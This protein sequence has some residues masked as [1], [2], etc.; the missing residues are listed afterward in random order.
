MKQRSSLFLKIAFAL[1]IAILA[2]LVSWRLTDHNYRKIADPVDKL[3]HPN[4]PL[5]LVSSLFREV[6]ALDV[7][8]R[9]LANQKGNINLDTFFFQVQTINT[10]LSRLD[11]L[12]SDNPEQ[13]ARIN[14]MKD[15]LQ[16]KVE[17]FQQLA[18][19]NK[20]YKQSDTLKHEVEKLTQYIN[21]ESVAAQPKNAGI[22]KEATQIK[23]TTSVSKD[24]FVEQKRSTWDKIWGKKKEKVKLPPVVKQETKEEKVLVVDTQLLAKDNKNISR[25][26]TTIKTIAT[27]QNTNLN[28]I[29]KKRADLEETNSML[30]AAFISVLTEIE[31]AAKVED[32]S[33]NLAAKSIIESGLD[34][35]R[36]LLIGF[37]VLSAILATLIFYD[38]AKS[39]RYKKALIIAKEQADEAGMAK[40][41]F[42]SNMSHELRTPLQSI[43]GYTELVQRE[44]DSK[45]QQHFLK[46][47]HQSSLH[48]LHIVNEIL[49]FNKINT[50]KF[51]IMSQPFILA[52]VVSQVV[53]IIKIQANRKQLK[54]ETNLHELNTQTTLVGDPFRLKQI[55]LNLLN[56]AIKFTEK[57][58]VSLNIQNVA[59]Q[60]CITCCFEI[61]D[62]GIGIAEEHQQ[63][64]FNEFEQAPTGQLPQGSGLGLSI[65]KALVEL[66]Q[67]SITLDSIVGRGSTFLVCIPYATETNNNSLGIETFKQQENKNPA[68]LVWAIDDDPF[69]LE[70]CAEVFKRNKIPYQCFK[71][72]QEMLATPIPEVLNYILMDIRMPEYSGMEL[73]RLMKNRL[74]ENHNAQFIAL[75]AQVLPEEIGDLFASG[76][77]SL[78]RKPFAI[79]Q[80]LK[81][82][83]INEEVKQADMPSLN[84]LDNINLLFK[85]ETEQDLD[86]IRKNKNA[87]AAE[88]L[89][90]VFHKLASRLSQLGYKEEGRASRILELQLRKGVYHQESIE[91]L[92]KKLALLIA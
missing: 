44:E 34:Y 31:N 48:L 57:G 30:F 41:R 38:I 40:Q 62:T 23:T 10:K 24:T 82:I 85:K 45:S 12:L 70:L 77:D 1:S 2:I 16:Q 86:F 61:S 71:S 37:S 59:D 28:R 55:L 65:V 3:A 63:Q 66:Q 9:T 49:D 54:F 74:P 47:V 11:S 92:T 58:T 18:Q 36:R 46:V 88:A 76:F 53:E 21:K 42:L 80:L 64:I 60:D 6:V 20:D 81:E 75:T 27:K 56:N 89:S 22:I 52:E 14:R 84:Q 26:G 78:I 7:S 19:L 17:Q 13:T 72:A 33:N 39:N 4:E 79:K 87:A 68:Q 50:D 67:G 5:E 8:Q 15:L 83:G 69:I 35:N 25:I 91:E 32:Q 51:V 29:E 90:E 43:I 73:V